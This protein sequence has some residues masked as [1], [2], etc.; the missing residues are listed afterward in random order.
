MK[1]RKSRSKAGG[2][3]GRCGWG[4]GCRLNK[5]SGK[6]Q[7]GET[8]ARAGELG[9][10]VGALGVVHS[11]FLWGNDISDPHHLYSVPW[12]GKFQGQVH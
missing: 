6:T 3:T 9:L 7:E 5:Q 8:W 1:K 12:E 10:A 11:L 2:K 4:V